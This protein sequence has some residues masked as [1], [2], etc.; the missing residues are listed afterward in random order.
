[1]VSPLKRNAGT[2]VAF[3][4]RDRTHLLLVI[5][6]KLRRCESFVFSWTVTGG[7]LRGLR[8]S[9][10]SPIP[11]G[12]GALKRNRHRADFEPAPGWGFDSPRRLRGGLAEEAPWTRR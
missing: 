10:R 6:A 8:Q 11:T 12:R 1:M 2:E 7:Y 3:D 4:N 9:D 5:T